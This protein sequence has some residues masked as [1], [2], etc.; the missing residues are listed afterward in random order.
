MFGKRCQAQLECNN[1]TRNR[2]LK[3][4][5]CLGSKGKNVTE[6]FRETLRM[7]ITKRIAG[8]SV[9]IRKMSVRTL[10]RGRPPLKQKKRPLTTD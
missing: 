3:E 2:D 1:G 5:L 8:A 4:Q 6:T 9:R 10:W 7:E